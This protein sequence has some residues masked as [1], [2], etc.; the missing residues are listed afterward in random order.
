MQDENAETA[1]DMPKSNPFVFLDFAIGGI[2]GDERVNTGTPQRVIFELF[3]DQ[4]PITAENFRCLCTG[5]RGNG[6]RSRLCYRNTPVHRV[7]PNFALEGAFV[8]VVVII[9][10]FI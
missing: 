1:S 2:G 10:D 7:V 8:V 6:Q 9:H 4:L 3:A 5:E